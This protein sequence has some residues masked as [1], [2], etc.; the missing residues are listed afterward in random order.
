LPADIFCTGQAAPV[1]FY[2][3]EASLLISIITILFPPQNHETKQKIS[4]S[5]QRAI[6]SLSNLKPFNPIAASGLDIIRHCYQRIIVAES[7][8]SVMNAGTAPYETPINIFNGLMSD[9][10]QEDLTQPQILQLESSQ[11]NLTSEQ[12]SSVDLTR[13]FPND[14]NP[15]YWLDQLGTI[16]PFI[17]DQDS[18]NLW[19]S[20]LFDS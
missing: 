20:F 17:S 14:F 5:L 15:T 11:P 7:P 6:E 19:E 18:G 13:L 4:H 3:V 2:T 1:S 16:D 12:A 8:S 10:N 9:L